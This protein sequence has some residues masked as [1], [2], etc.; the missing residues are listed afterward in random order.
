MK[1]T[2]RLFLFFLLL[3]S[4]P[5]RA[6][7]IAGVDLPARLADFELRSAVDHERAYPGYGKSFQYS[8]PGVKATVYVYNKELPNLPD[9]VTSPQA[10]QE[11]LTARSEVRHFH[12]DMVI[13]KREELLMIGTTPV[14]HDEYQYREGSAGDEVSSHLYLTVRAGNFLKLRV[15]YL[16]HEQFESSQ[17]VVERFLKALYA[18]SK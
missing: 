7:P 18:P 8:A 10:R 13:G 9:G 17:L 11:F 6:D 1:L 5:L 3:V 12:A 14:L 2:T 4:A 15:T 16:A